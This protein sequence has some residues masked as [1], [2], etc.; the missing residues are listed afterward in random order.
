MAQS[1]QCDLRCFWLLLLNVSILE[2]LCKLQLYA[3]ERL[4]NAVLPRFWLP[5]RTIPRSDDERT[6]RQ[7]LSSWAGEFLSYSKTLDYA[8]LILSRN[9]LSNFKRVQQTTLGKTLIKTWKTVFGLSDDRVN[10]DT[11][12]LHADGDS[13]SAI[14]YISSLRASGVVGIT[15]SVLFESPTLVQLYDTLTP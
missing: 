4:L 14:R 15:I 10:G 8:S 6:D 13:I 7:T 2:A 11:T 1:E 3:A 12:F 5:I 9:R